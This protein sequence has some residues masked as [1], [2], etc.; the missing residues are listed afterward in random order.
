MARFSTTITAIISLL[1]FSHNVPAL[2]V[3]PGSACAAVCLDDPEGD[4]NDA[5]Q[6]TTTPKDVV[7]TDAKYNTT[8]VGIK[9]KSCMQCLQ[10]SHVSKGTESDLDWYLCK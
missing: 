6:S 4:P 7:C 9:Y 10:S 3:T 2:Q 1:I 5:A 8:A